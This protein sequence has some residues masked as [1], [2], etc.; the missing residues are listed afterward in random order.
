MF[1]LFMENTNCLTEQDIE[2]ALSSL[3]LAY[4]SNIPQYLLTS[5]KHAKLTVYIIAAH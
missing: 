5:Q 4:H 1:R 3:N 2:Q